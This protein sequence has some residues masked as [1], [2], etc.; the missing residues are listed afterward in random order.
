V[1][2]DH[3][4][5]HALKAIGKESDKRGLV[6]QGHVLV[7]IEVE[8]TREEW[9]K[10]FLSGVKAGYVV[11]QAHCFNVHQAS[12]FSRHFSFT[13]KMIEITCAKEAF[14]ASKLGHK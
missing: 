11:N 10:S 7:G 2:S 5:G 14:S 6:L 8:Y 4:I 13:N 9:T 1:I 12:T 3:G